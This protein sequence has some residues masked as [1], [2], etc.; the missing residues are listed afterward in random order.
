MN[1][2]LAERL[3]EIHQEKQH[4]PWDDK[5]TEAA[6]AGAHGRSK[7]V[8]TAT[9]RQVYNRIKGLR[10]IEALARPPSRGPL[11]PTNRGLIQ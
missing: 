8:K 2:S 10:C 9:Q 1:V 6:A 11:S 5:M 3:I 4:E 7:I